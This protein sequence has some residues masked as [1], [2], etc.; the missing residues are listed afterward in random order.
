MSAI[1]FTEPSVKHTTVSVQNVYIGK[2]Q[3]TQRV[4]KQIQHE[5][6]INKDGT[7]RGEPWGYVNYYWE[8]HYPYKP[9]HIL[10]VTPQGEL[11]RFYY[12]VGSYTVAHNKS[13]GIHEKIPDIDRKTILPQFKEVCKFMATLPQLYIAI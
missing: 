10:W 6:L 5:T 12:Y 8:H 3:L 2:R 13:Y 7:L 1:Q 9:D 11:R 4:F